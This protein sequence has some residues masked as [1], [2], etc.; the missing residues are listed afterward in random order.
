[1][2][3]F[4]HFY[5]SQH[6][7]H[8][9]RSLAGFLL[10][11]FSSGAAT[12]GALVP[13]ENPGFEEIAG[14]PLFNEFSF[15]APPGW[16]LHDPNLVAANGNGP[17]FYVGTLTPFEED[18]IGNPGVYVNFP[19]GAPEGQRVAIAFN[20]VGSDGIGEYGI[21]QTLD[22]ILEPNMTYTLQ[23]EIGN[24]A[25]GTAM[26]GQTFNLNGFPG[27]RVDLMAGEVILDSDD[28]GLTGLIDEGMWMTSTVTYTTGAMHDQ[29]NERLRIRLVNKN[30]L[31]PIDPTADIEVDFDDVRLDASPV[32]CM[33]DASG[34]GSVDF[35][36]LNLVLGNWGSSV[37]AGTMGDVTGDGVV[38]F[39]D[40]NAVLGNWGC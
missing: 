20:F 19:D 29:L 36:D 37:P 8:H 30:V 17:T 16:E 23:V 33:G 11:A 26:S 4:F 2:A 39:G 7:L 6:M 3:A 27:Y 31:D 21:Y 40:L 1:M 32:A 35:V 13:I 28:D 25:T 12:L 15:T 34:D 38:D 24:I 18:P 5:R 9:T 14:E 10:M 22:A